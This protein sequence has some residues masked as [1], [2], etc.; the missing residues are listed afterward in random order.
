MTCV[1]CGTCFNLE[2]RNTDS[3]KCQVTKTYLPGPFAYRVVENLCGEQVN[4]CSHCSNH[5]RKRKHLTK[6]KAM[7]PMDHYLLSLLNLEFCSKIDLRSKKRIKKVLL[8]TTNNY[9]FTSFAPLQ[10]L[11]L[12]PQKVQ[13]WWNLNLNTSFYI[14][15]KTSRLIRL[16]IKH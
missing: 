16:N 2:I 11:I 7:I 10:L 8:E 9:R 5:I 15:G 6:R 4:I 3:V 14:G 12:N 1:L 13:T